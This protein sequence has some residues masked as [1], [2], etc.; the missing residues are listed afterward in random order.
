MSDK[1]GVSLKDNGD[2]TVHVTG[3]K[4]G[5]TGGGR[6]SGDLNIQTQSFTGIHATRQDTGKYSQNPEEWRDGGSFFDG[7]FGM[8]LL[9]MGSGALLVGTVL[10]K[11]LS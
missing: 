7:C 5:P 3:Y 11:V 9:V 4:G 2:G 10:I 8:F 6:V 1:W